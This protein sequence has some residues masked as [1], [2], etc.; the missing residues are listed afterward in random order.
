MADDPILIEKIPPSRPA[1]LYISYYTLANL[2]LDSISI[3][4]YAASGGV[5]RSDAFFADS[6]RLECNGRTTVTE[7]VEAFRKEAWDRDSYYTY[8]TR[9]L[10]TLLLLDTSQPTL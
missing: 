10:S 1:T 4:S 7:A 6:K 3:L 5:V 9:C 2:P 8:P